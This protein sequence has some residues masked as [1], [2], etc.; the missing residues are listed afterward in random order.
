M[1]AAPSEV[2]VLARVNASLAPVQI[3]LC[4]DGTPVNGAVDSRFLGRGGVRATPAIVWLS[5]VATIN[6]LVLV[7]NLIPA[8]PLDGGRIA[9]AF[10]WWRTGGRSLAAA[11]SAPTASAA[12]CAPPWHGWP[13]P[14]H[15]WA[16]GP[17]R[18]SGRRP[19][20]PSGA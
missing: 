10:I 13:S 2:A 12:A 3:L 17:D 14:P 16:L 11:S 19:A 5:W 18:C 8:F 7:F 1:G 15:Q 9:H 6:A 4:H 20:D